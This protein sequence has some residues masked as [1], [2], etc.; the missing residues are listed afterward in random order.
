[1]DALVSTRLS[2]IF[3]H[4]LISDSSSFLP[5]SRC[6]VCSSSGVKPRPVIQ[7]RFLRHLSNWLSDEDGDEDEDEEGESEEDM[8]GEIFNLRD[9]FKLPHLESI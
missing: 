8:W 1:M 3:S 4:L 9:R 5:R 6:R 7:E 2:F